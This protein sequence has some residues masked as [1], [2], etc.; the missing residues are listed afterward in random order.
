V[1]SCITHLDWG[2]QHKLTCWLEPTGQNIDTSIN[3]GLSLSRVSTIYSL[4]YSIS[5]RFG[6]D[7]SQTYKILTTNNYFII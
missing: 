1:S 3:E 2:T 7:L 5:C 4:W 6:Q